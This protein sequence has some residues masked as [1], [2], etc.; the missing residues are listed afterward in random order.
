MPSVCYETFGIILIESFRLGTPVIA[1]R[2]GP[3]PEIVQR[4]GGGSLFETED[5]LISAMRGLQHQPEA[6]AGQ[7][8]AAR[9]AFLDIWHEDKVLAAYGAALARAAHEKGDRA[10]TAALEAGAF[11][12]A[13]SA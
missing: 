12:N 6:R 3:F 4:A 13:A 7:G 2:L 10:L 1:R 9:M 5:D 8:A 11:E